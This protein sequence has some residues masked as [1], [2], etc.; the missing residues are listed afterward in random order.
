MPGSSITL[1]D[2]RLHDWSVVIYCDACRVGRPLRLDDLILSSWFARPIAEAVARRK[3]TCR[4]C[5][6][7]RLTIHVNRAKVGVTERVA[8]FEQR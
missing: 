5:G 7:H 1:A 2:A 3:F 6:G 4:T 8:E